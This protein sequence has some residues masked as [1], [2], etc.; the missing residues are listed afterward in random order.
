MRELVN[1]YMVHWG[2]DCCF[3]TKNVDEG[4]QGQ[5]HWPASKA[6]R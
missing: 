6:S 5:R 3:G 2:L 4:I 1:R